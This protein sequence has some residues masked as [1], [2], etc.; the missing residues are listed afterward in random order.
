MHHCNGFF[1]AHIMKETHVCIQH[2]VHIIRFNQR[3]MTSHSLH[4]HMREEWQWLLQLTV[5]CFIIMWLIRSLFNCFFSLCKCCLVLLYQREQIIAVH[6]WLLWSTEL[7]KAD[8]Q[9]RPQLFI[10]TLYLYTHT[11]KYKDG[12]SSVQLLM[13]DSVRS[14]HWWHY[15]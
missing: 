14:K 15:L 12:N 11:Q 13:D 8:I 4:V 1:E 3:P 5:Y 2:T 6:V 7:V 9:Y 10:Y